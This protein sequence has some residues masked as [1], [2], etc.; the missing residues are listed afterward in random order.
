MAQPSSEL[1]HYV[2]KAAAQA[3]LASEPAEAPTTGWTGYILMTISLCRVKANMAV[4]RY[5]VRD[6]DKD[7][8]ATVEII[9]FANACET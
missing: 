8:N 5:Q 6:G 3:I 2:L 4:I 9:Q 7:S 1:L